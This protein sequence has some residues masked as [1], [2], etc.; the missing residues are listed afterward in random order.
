M[1]C[2]FTRFTIK[3]ILNHILK[4]S[5]GEKLDSLEMYGAKIPNKELDY[6]TL[7]DII[8]CPVKVTIKIPNVCKRVKFT[9]ERKLNSCG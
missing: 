1:P 6:R 3:T 2:V 7:I 5:D 9:L 8:S 4:L